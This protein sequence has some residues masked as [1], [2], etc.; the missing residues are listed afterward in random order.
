MP[1]ALLHAQKDASNER[2]VWTQVIWKRD[3]WK[4]IKFRSFWGPLVILLTIE[5]VNNRKRIK[6]EAPWTHSEIRSG[7][8]EWEPRIDP[9]RDLK[10]EEI[11][12]RKRSK[13]DGLQTEETNEYNTEMNQTL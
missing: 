9:K 2:E 3:Y 10:F 6:Q 5:E 8:E 12:Y 11:W 1:Q 13:I 4:T 7:A